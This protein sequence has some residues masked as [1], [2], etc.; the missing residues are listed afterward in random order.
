MHFLPALAPT[1]SPGSGPSRDNQATRGAALASST[2]ERAPRCSPLT[3]LALESNGLCPAALG[4]LSKVLSSLVRLQVLALS[5]NRLLLD[6]HPALASAG[7]G[8]GDVRRGG[9]GLEEDKALERF[10]SSLCAHCHALRYLDFAPKSQVLTCPKAE[11]RSSSVPRSA[12]YHP[13]DRKP[14]SGDED[15]T[16]RECKY[17]TWWPVDGGAERGGIQGQKPARQESGLSLGAALWAREVLEQYR[18]A[19]FKVRGEAGS[20][21]FRDARLHSAGESEQEA[22]RDWNEEAE[23][24]LRRLLARESI[25]RID[26]TGVAVESGLG[27]AIARVAAM[28]NGRG[29]TAGTEKGREKKE[30]GTVPVLAAVLKAKWSSIL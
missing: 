24:V 13:R 16:G 29:D 19:V 17:R 3:H 7:G 25:E 21:K 10:V 5:G 11:A 26:L 30:W 2:G 8:G 23:R 15:R 27:K 14:Q 28:V 20:G 18:L 4:Q 6:A 9:L 12:P 1:P 22:L